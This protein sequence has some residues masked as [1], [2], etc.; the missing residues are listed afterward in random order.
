MNGTK[1]I[2]NLNWL[3]QTNDS[4]NK[5]WQSSPI[6]DEDDDDENNDDSSDDNEKKEDG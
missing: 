6:V 3:G 1:L 5:I 2:R 4:N